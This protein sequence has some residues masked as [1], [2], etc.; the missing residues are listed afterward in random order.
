MSYLVDAYLVD[1]NVLSELRKRDRANPH[2]VGWFQEREAKEL[3]L[4]VLTL[5]E[6]R[7]GVERIRRRDPASAT[8]LE[9][10][11]D[12]TAQD[13]RDRIIGVDRAIAERWGHMGIP[14]PVPDV[15]G[16]IA[17]TALERDL[18]VV[19]RNTRHLAGTGARHFDPFDNG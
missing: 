16:L 11:L 7:R 9:K 2:V 13:F 19:S 10:W 18:I 15:D 14:D 17:A 8:A 4:S 12:R 1:T 3:F 6:L 5:G